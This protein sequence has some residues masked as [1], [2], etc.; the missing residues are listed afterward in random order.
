ME[1]G[2]DLEGTISLFFGMRPL[3]GKHILGRGEIYY[4]TLWPLL[5]KGFDVRSETAIQ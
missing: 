2:Q 3:R 1:R 4:L 5:G